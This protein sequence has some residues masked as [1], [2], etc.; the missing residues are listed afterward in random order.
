MK[1]KQNDFRNYSIPYSKEKLFAQ[2]I[3]QNK[4]LKVYSSPNKRYEWPLVGD[5]LKEMSFS[6]YL[7]MIINFQI[8]FYD[9]TLTVKTE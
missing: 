6:N 3:P 1:S 2:K 4:T 7:E 8:G 5:H 9:K